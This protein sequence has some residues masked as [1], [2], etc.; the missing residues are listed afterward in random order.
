M[1]L[2]AVL[3]AQRGVD[4]ALCSAGVAAQWVEFGDNSDHFARL[5]ELFG[6][7]EPG[8]S[9]PHDHRVVLIDLHFIDFHLDPILPK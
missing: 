6:G 8:E 3:L 1:Q 5:L 4:S 2:G 7:G 9:G